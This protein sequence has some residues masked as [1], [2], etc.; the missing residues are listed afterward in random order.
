VG[1]RRTY[2]GFFNGTPMLSAWRYCLQTQFCR[3]CMNSYRDMNELNVPCYHSVSW[4]ITPSSSDRSFDSCI[5]RKFVCLPARSYQILSV[6]FVTAWT[7]FGLW[8][9]ER[10]K[11][12]VFFE[13]S[14]VVTVK[15]VASC[16]VTPCRLVKIYCYFNYVGKCLPYSSMSLQRKYCFSE[17]T[18]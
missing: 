5:R 9:E 4:L 14:T 11:F 3:P 16:I 2:S 1:R 8:V 6:D 7:T 18:L 10:L 15:N 13:A 17:Q 12:Y